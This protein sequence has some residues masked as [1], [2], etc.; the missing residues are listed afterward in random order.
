MRAAIPPIR[1][2]AHIALTALCAAIAL[3]G[4]SLGGASPPFRSVHGGKAI[5]EAACAG[6]HG[7]DGSGESQD[8]AGFE[9]P[10]TFP[11][12]NKCDEST[13]EYTID[14]AASIRNGGPARGFSPI[15]PAFGEVLDRRQ[16]NEVVHYLRSLCRTSG[17]PPGELNLPRALVTEKAFPEKEVVF[18]TS[19]NTRKPAGVDNEFVYEQTL[20][21]LDQ[22]EIAIPFGWVP[23]SRGLTG[24]LGDIAVGDKH[25]LYSHL[26]MP[27]EASVAQAHGSILSLQGEII[28]ATGDA[29][30][31]LGAGEPALNVFAMYD[32]LRPHNLFLQLQP[33]ITVPRHADGGPK[34]VYLRSAVGTTLA[35]DNGYGQQFSPAFEL[36]VSRDLDAGART[37][38]DVIPELQITLSRRQHVRGAVGYRIPVNDTAARSPQFV[39]YVLWDWAD[40]GLFEGWK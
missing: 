25:V 38:F 39:G 19:I 9:R 35:R 5:Y 40:G 14:Y 24:G 30:R 11:H 8:R 7:A 37:D 29:K 2:A 15:M 34:N 31:G 13:P 10:T 4:L 1:R 28:L 32:V 21:R 12:F 22:L 18:T 36:I 16:I 3:R 33:G 6:C 17:W 20:G 26:D 23:G 27:A